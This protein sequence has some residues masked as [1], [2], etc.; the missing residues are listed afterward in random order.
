MSTTA[1][2]VILWAA[3]AVCWLPLVTVCL[4]MD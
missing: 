2:T 3:F 1:K 4:F